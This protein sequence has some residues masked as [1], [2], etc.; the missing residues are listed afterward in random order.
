[1]DKLLNYTPLLTLISFI[2]TYFK[3]SKILLFTYISRMYPVHNAMYPAMWNVS[4]VMYPVHNAMY[5]AM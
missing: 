4:N 1:M 2:P 5:P 3:I